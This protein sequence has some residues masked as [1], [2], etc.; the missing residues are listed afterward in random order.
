MAPTGI[1]GRLKALYTGGEKEKEIPPFSTTTAVSLLVLYTLIYVIPFY[2]SSTTRPSPQLSRDAPTVIRGRIRSVTLSCIIVCIATFGILSSVRNGDEIR[3]F[4]QMGYFPIGFFETIKCVGLTA[5]LFIGPLF[6]EGIAQ[7]QWRDWIRLRGLG[8]LK[9]WIPYR[10][11]IAGPVTEE[12]LFRSA[13]VPLLLLSKTPTTT[14]IFLTP[15]VFGLAH[16]HHFYEIQNHAPTRANGWSDPPLAAP[17]L[18]HDALWGL[19]YFSLS[20]NGES[21]GGD[22]RTCVFSVDGETIIGPDVGASK[23]S[24][25]VTRRNGEFEYSLDN[26]LLFSPSRGC[27]LLVAVFVG[28]V[29]ERIR[30]GEILIYKKVVG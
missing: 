24:E 17:I 7:G 23:K 12:V 1:Y 4:H 27:V 3:S 8:A 29:C 28:F 10:N 22:M 26:Y 11:I 21:L 6:E 5:I 14:I 2:L 19:R 20:P 16:V 18:I 25:D 30:F 15:V 13:S 9:G